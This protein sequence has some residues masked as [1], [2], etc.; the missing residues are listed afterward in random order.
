[1]VEKK[2]ASSRWPRTHQQK[3]RKIIA[4][5]FHLQ[6]DCHHRRCLQCAAA[7]HFG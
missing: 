1:M 5:F 4:Y 3:E 2:R 7:Q 6:I